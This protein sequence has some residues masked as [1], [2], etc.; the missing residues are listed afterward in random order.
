M[1]VAAVRDA[2][3][4][5]A[6]ADAVAHTI[7]RWVGGLSVGVAFRVFGVQVAKH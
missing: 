1:P 2:A 3:R 6:L 7:D 5:P 4:D